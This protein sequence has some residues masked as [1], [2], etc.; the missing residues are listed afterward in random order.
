[1]ALHFDA[2]D[3]E[4]DGRFWIFRYVAIKADFALAD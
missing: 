4:A 3:A 2:V 1:M